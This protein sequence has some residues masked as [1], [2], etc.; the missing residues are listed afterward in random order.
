[1]LATVVE[2][3]ELEEDEVEVV[4][5][6]LDSASAVVVAELVVSGAAPSSELHAA[7]SRAHPRSAPAQRPAPTP[8]PPSTELARAT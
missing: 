8:T 1:M 5:V 7:R 3:V 4:D 2:V 6:E